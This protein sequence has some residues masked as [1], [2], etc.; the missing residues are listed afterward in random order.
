MQAR[1]SQGQF[2]RAILVP[3][4]LHCIRAAVNIVG[5]LTKDLRHAIDIHEKARV[6]RR[7]RRHPI[8]DQ[9]GTSL[10]RAALPS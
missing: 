8:K 9:N 2:Q 7:V 1:A 3:Q 6:A 5:S 10:A 4:I